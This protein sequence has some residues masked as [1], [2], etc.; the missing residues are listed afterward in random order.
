MHDAAHW[1]IVYSSENIGFIAFVL[2]SFRK[3]TDGIFDF[4]CIAS[5][6]A[7]RYRMAAAKPVGNDGSWQSGRA[8]AKQLLGEN[9]PQTSLQYAFKRRDC[10]RR[11]RLL[12]AVLS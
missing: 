8:Q 4:I 2:Y 10:N 5:V 3:M 7:Q 1:Q 12:V 11:R 6:K 9:S